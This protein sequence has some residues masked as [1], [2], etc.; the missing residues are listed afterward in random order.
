VT[1]RQRDRLDVATVNTGRW[2]V[3]TILDLAMVVAAIALQ[4]TGNN[5]ELVRALLANGYRVLD[6]S[7]VRGQDSTVLGFDPSELTLIRPV[8]YLLSARQYAG[9]GAGPDTVKTKW[10]MG[11]LFIHKATGRRVLILCVHL[12]ASQ[13]YPRRKRIALA[14]IHRVRLF[15]ARFRCI[16]IAMGDWN[17]TL[18]SPV[19]QVLLG[20]G[21]TN[22]DL[23]GGELATHG[24]RAIDLIWW[25]LTRRLKFLGHWAVPGPGDHH[26][27]IAAFQV[28]RR[29]RRR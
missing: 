7:G 23:E 24:H 4:E 25:R 26:A 21:W 17:A 28:R 6:G 14:A 16:V 5:P 2:T 11:G 10:A 29:L 9:K 18:K 3:R 13:Q 1:A 15:G 19:L 20:G 8:A 27:K 12:V 22:T